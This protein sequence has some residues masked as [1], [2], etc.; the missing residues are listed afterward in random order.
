MTEAEL[1]E[2]YEDERFDGE[3]FAEFVARMLWE[4]D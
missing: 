4:D 3:S 2:I 1:Y